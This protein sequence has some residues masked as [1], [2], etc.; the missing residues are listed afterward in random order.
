M[1]GGEGG[2][3]HPSEANEAQS[4]CLG[5]HEDAVLLSGSCHGRVP[6]RKTERK[7]PASLAF[8]RQPNSKSS[9]TLG[10]PGAMASAAA[11]PA[12]HCSSPRAPLSGTLHPPLLPNSRIHNVWAQ[13]LAKTSLS[14]GVLVGFHDRMVVARV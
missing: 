10:L 14:V 4:H 8:N 12:V 5:H 3:S 1:T 2:G 7:I 9:L 6:G 13:W 11:A